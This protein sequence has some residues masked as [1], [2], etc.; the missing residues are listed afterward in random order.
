MH[1]NHSHEE[2]YLPA[3]GDVW[4]SMENMSAGLCTDTLVDLTDAA[5]DT[6]SSAAG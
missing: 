1:T 3:Y 6:S 2:W 4:F 5:S